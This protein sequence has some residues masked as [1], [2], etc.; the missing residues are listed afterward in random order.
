MGLLWA[1][2]Q[3]Q[4]Q[5]DVVVGGVAGDDDLFGLPVDGVGIA[6]GVGKGAPVGLPRFQVA[7]VETLGV[8]QRILLAQ[9]A[10]RR[11]SALTML[12]C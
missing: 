6:A 11:I 3:H 9:R 7:R 12:A 2:P 8:F 5:V 4:R 1:P 10:Q